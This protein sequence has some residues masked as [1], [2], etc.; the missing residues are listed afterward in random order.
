MKKKE[1]KVYKAFEGLDLK[2]I[3]PEGQRT[4]GAEGIAANAANVASTTNNMISA[5]S[6]KANVRDGVSPRDV[7]ANKGE[8]VG[9]MVATGGAAFLSTYG[10]P[11]M[12]SKA[13]I[14]MF[15]KPVGKL[16]GKLTTDK[17][18]IATYNTQED[19]L[20]SDD[21]TNAS[22]KAYANV[23]QHQTTQSFAEGGE[24]TDPPKKDNLDGFLEKDRT[25]ASDNTR[26]ET[27]LFSPNATRF[28]TPIELREIQHK[29][30]LGLSR[31]EEFNK[32]KDNL[33]NYSLSGADN[34]DYVAPN[35]V[36]IEVDQKAIDDHKE[37]Y[38]TAGYKMLQQEAEAKRQMGPDR[39]LATGK[40]EYPLIDPISLL[41]MPAYLPLKAATRAGK[42]A[43]FAAE[44]INPIGGF[45]GAKPGMARV[46]SLLEADVK[47]VT[48]LK[49][50]PKDKE[51]I[52]K[53][54]RNVFKE[55]YKDPEF[56]RRIDDLF[57]RKKNPE[58][59]DKDFFDGLTNKQVYAALSERLA[60][61]LPDFKSGYR[62][63]AFIKDQV[64]DPTKPKLV[65]SINTLDSNLKGAD[66]AGIYRP[67]DGS[68]DIMDNLSPA[69]TRSTTVHELTHS[70]TKA[71]ENLPHRFVKD[72][73][74][75]FMT[76]V[77]LEKHFTKT[78]SKE[79]QALVKK[80]GKEL[81]E[82][83]SEPTELHARMNQ[84]RDYRTVSMNKGPW[85]DWTVAE[86]NKVMSDMNAQ[87]LLSTRFMQFFKHKDGKTSEALVK[88]MNYMFG[89]SAVGATGVAV[90]Q[91]T[92]DGRKKVPKFRTGGELAKGKAIVL[93]G[94][95]HK[96][97][98]NK[99]TDEKGEIVAETEREELLLDAVHAKAI[100][101]HI[102]LFKDT[103]DDAHYIHL[104]RIAKEMVED[105]ID[106]SGKYS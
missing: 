32:V 24:I 5:W 17:S 75:I 66:A 102:K 11:P 48:P 39:P 88:M 62:K 55:Q 19:N 47:A 51:G 85:D 91:N 38:N 72:S 22:K 56:T 18:K 43:K 58:I 10:I 8:A 79:N 46:E 49:R 82:Y 1:K 21:A 37:F 59:W 54:A 44:M 98:G 69:R 86:L 42:I 71:D 92:G 14:G 95:L 20:H 9:E 73:K 105:S 93:G 97:G 50:S 61:G 99:V 12:I 52:L 106:N 100:N 41:L 27:K 77:E 76:A 83:F 34:N 89:A 60:G 53:N 81:L 15:T 64:L 57:D 45:R 6:Q 29:E 78:V 84:M 31:E 7:S 16:I 25:V 96:D 63:K 101:K 70:I 3:M 74:Q 87:D 35:K 26:V 67:K 30:E 33:A 80:E 2:N 90:N 13:V 103:G 68:I 65:N 36:N 94:D 4:M 23:A 104:G 28:S 40:S